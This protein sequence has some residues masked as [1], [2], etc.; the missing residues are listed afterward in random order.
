MCLQGAA[1]ENSHTHAV[2]PTSG[3][4]NAA[5]R[6]YTTPRLSEFGTVAALTAG[7]SNPSGFEAIA[8]GCMNAPVF[9]APCMS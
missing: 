5:K 8:F 3:S 4:S 1:M 7:G 9:I 2:M 6:A